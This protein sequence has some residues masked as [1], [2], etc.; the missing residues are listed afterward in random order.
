[1]FKNCATF[2]NCIREIN[3]TK[4]DHAKDINVVMPMYSLVEYSDNYSKTSEGLWQYYREELALN[5]ARS[6]DNFSGNRASFKSRQ[7]ITGST[8]NNDTKNVEIMVPL[9]YLSNF[10]RN[11]KMPLINCEINLI[12]T[13]SS[14]CVLSNAAQNQVT[15]FAITDTKLHV[16]V[17]T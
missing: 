6:L 5:D 7:K 12:L 10:W 16:S 14:N 13:W 4:T 15:T 9:K 11:L 2:T 1:M 8:E 17:V 3:N